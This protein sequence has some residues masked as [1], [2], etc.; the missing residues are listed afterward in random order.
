[1][2]QFIIKK[3]INKLKKQDITNYANQQ[4]IYLTQKE[5]DI[6]YDY[7]KNR[8]SE[9]LN[10]NQEKLLKEIKEKVTPNTYKKIEELYYFYKNKI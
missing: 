3:Y 8:H 1:M 6:I 4:N 5:I 10:G 2:N 9:F 7:I